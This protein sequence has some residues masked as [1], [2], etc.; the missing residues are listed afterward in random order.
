MKQQNKRVL[1]AKIG[2]DGH[3]RGAKVV[4]R[5]LLDAGIDVEY[6]GIR[7]RVEDVIATSVQKDIGVLGLSFLSG[8][9]MTLVPKILQQ[10]KEAGKAE[11]PVVVG[12]IILQQQVQELLAMGVKK[13]FLPGT[14]L[15]EIV[16][17]I[18]SA[19]A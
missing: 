10:L 19:L 8:D 13:V 11:L 1:I 4:A 2:L 15:Q 18:Q 14:P 12:G 5:A 3:D 17:F 6:T 16:G 9:H 7:A